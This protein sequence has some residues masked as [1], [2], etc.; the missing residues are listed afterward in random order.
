VEYKTVETDHSFYEA[1]ASL[2]V[3]SLQKDELSIRT[4]NNKKYNFRFLNE[5]DGDHVRRLASLHIP[6]S[7]P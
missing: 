6:I 1:Y 7:A 4:H 5:G 3:F 2:R